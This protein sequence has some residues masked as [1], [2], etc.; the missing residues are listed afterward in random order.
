MEISLWIENADL[1]VFIEIYEKNKPDWFMKHLLKN[2]P[3][4]VNLKEI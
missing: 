1:I 2:S 3:N 4:E